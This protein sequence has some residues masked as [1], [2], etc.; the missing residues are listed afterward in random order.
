MR[1]GSTK[2]AAMV[3]LLKQAVFFLKKI[4]RFGSNICI[5]I[6]GRILE[7]VKFDGALCGRD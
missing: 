6:G 4:E 1:A 3:Y 5:N 7:K 2:D